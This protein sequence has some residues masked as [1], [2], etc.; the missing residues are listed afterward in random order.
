MLAWLKWILVGTGFSALFIIILLVS[1]NHE[2]NTRTIQEV[3]TA[4]QNANIG[5]MRSE[6]GYSL[7]KEDAVTKLVQETIEKQKNNG[8]G[9]NIHYAFLDEDR[10]QTQKEDDM[11]AVQFL[12]EQINNHGDVVSEAESVVALKEGA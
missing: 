8:N 11:V 3:E 2:A 6:D 7:N 4:L 9:L 10:N 5:Q 12:I 1:N